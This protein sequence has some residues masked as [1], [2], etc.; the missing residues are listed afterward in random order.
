MPD[1]KGHLSPAEI[2]YIQRWVIEYHGG[3]PFPC[4]LCGDTTWYI[5]EYVT[6]SIIF[7]SPA[8]LSA[9]WSPTPL[10]IVRM[11]CTRCGYVVSLNAAT[12]GLYPKSTASGGG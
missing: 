4:P 6:Q 3:S 11:V 5:D 8:L 1:P 7:P 12:L 9:A 2:A 10:A